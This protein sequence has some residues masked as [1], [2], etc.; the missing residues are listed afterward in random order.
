MSCSITI[1]KANRPAVDPN[2]VQDCKTLREEGYSV[3]PT[4]RVKMDMECVY[5]YGDVVRAKRRIFNFA[6]IKDDYC[7]SDTP[8]AVSKTDD[9]IVFSDG[10]AIV[11]INRN[12]VIKEY[13][14]QETL[15]VFVVSLEEL[16]CFSDAKSMYDELS[17]CLLEERN[18]HPCSSG[19]YAMSIQ[20][21]CIISRY[22][23][24][25]HLFDFF[26]EGKAPLYI[27]FTP[28]R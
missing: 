7:L 11:E 19:Y 1:Y 21:A 12:T 10:C 13:L 3:F 25:S 5:E 15:D 18:M 24:H 4:N 26:E 27:K 23:S 17:A 16:F 9:G 28:L 2:V 6:K 22:V 8:R 14:L 20:Q